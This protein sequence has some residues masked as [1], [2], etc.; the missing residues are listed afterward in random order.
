MA[1]TSLIEQRLVVFELLCAPHGDAAGTTVHAS[2]SVL[3]GLTEHGLRFVCRWEG[4]LGIQIVLLFL[5]VLDNDEVSVVSNQVFNERE[6]SSLLYSVAL[7]NRYVTLVY[8]LRFWLGG[9][10]R[11]LQRIQEVCSSSRTHNATHHLLKGHLICFLRIALQ[12]IDLLSDSF[13]VEQ[14]LHLLKDLVL[15]LFVSTCVLVETG[16][17]V[18]LISEF[19]M[20][21]LYWLLLLFF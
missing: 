14:V 20:D 7:S 10:S 9:S 18:L 1:Q 4:S 11:S 21:L 12:L 5:F 2:R 13:I 19:G 3:H 16:L 17:D 8:W 15:P 6:R